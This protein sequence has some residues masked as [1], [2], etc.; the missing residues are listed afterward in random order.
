MSGESY[1]VKNEGDTPKSV[2]DAVKADSSISEVDGYVV[3]DE[4]IQP[5]DAKA[6]AVAS[7]IANEVVNVNTTVD[8]TYENNYTYWVETRPRKMILPRFWIWLVY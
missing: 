5:E 3:D 7:I 6:M 1:Y 2:A 8:R 4:M